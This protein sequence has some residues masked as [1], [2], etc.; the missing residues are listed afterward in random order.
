MARELCDDVEFSP[1]DASRTELGYLAEV[2]SAAIEAGATTV[3]IPDTVGYTVPAEFDRLFRYLKEH[4]QRIDEIVLCRCTATT[5]S[6][7]PWRTAW[8]PSA[9]VPGR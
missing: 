3:N 1:E 7:W 4:V 2:V 6:A 8:P 5:I 9:P